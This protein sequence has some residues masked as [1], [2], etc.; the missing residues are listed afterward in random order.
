MNQEELAN[1]VSD[2]GRLVREFEGHK[3]QVRSFDIT[4]KINFFLAAGCVAG[5]F[6]DDAVN[7]WWLNQYVIAGILFSLI[8]FFSHKKWKRTSKK[9]QDLDTRIIHL[10]DEVD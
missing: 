8:S 7:Q 1:K 9:M 3:I 4:R 6:Y 5:I 10:S 2:R